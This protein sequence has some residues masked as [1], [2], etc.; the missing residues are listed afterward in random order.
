MGIGWRGYLPPRQTPFRAGVIRIE[1]VPTLDGG[2]AGDVLRTRGAVLLTHR[3]GRG[4]MLAV[5]TRIAGP[6]H[7]GFRRRSVPPGRLGMEMVIVSGHAHSGLGGWSPN[8]P[9]DCP[10]QCA[11][12]HTG[13]RGGIVS[14]TDSPGAT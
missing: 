14:V 11:R 1:P 4:W 7:G 5:G 13:Q 9:A 8:L 6:A 10:G 3:G 2:I 12:P